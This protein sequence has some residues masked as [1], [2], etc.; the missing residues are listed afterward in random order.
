[1]MNNIKNDLENVGFTRIENLFPLSDLDK[2][3]SII[4]T[5]MHTKKFPAKFLKSSMSENPI[6]VKDQQTEFTRPYS[7][8]IS[9]RKSE[10]FGLCHKIAKE[11]FNGNAHYLFDHAIYKM[12]GSQTITPWH[13]DQAYLGENFIP[14]IHFWIPFQNTD[15][16]NGAMRFVKNSHLKLIP[17]E[18]AYVQNP[19]ILQAKTIPTNEIYTMN[20]NKGDASL[21]TNLTL[22]STTANNGNHIRKAWIIHFG[23]KHQWCKHWLKFK[24]RLLKR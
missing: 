20:I 7:V 19:H 22:H 14:S 8:S 13:Q 9:L 21:H 2:C 16:N 11:Y 17:H 24:G 10:T 4:D 6:E 5:L 12:P 15:I 18:I 23:Q 1:M 3:E